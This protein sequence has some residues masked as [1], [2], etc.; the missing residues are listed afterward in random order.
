LN[1]KIVF[2]ITSA[3]ILIGVVSTLFVI[4]NDTSPENNKTDEVES[5][6]TSINLK[7]AGEGTK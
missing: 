4:Q 1:S 5:E 7:M 3:I 2:G 6:T